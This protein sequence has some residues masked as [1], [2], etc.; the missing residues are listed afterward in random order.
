MKDLETIRITLRV[1]TLC[2]SAANGS[3]LNDTELG[4]TSLNMKQDQN[5]RMTEKGFP[6]TTTFYSSL[7]TGATP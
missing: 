5:C 3:A 1:N 2:T 6:K 7:L 4:A